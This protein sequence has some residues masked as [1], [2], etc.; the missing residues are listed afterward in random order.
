MRQEHDKKDYILG[1][2]RK[3]LDQ[4]LFSIVRNLGSIAKHKTKDSFVICKSSY[5][6]FNPTGPY[7]PPREY[8]IFLELILWDPKG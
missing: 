5:L 7:A 8:T 2:D 6:S 3:L 4:S 1:A